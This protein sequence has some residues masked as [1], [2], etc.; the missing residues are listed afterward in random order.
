M[1]LEQIQQL[2]VHGES[3]TLELKKSTAQLRSACETACAFLNR[4]GIMGCFHLD[5]IA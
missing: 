5:S 2:I 4:Y 1:N 3:D